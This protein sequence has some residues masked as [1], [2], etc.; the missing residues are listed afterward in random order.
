MRLGMKVLKHMRSGNQS[1]VVS[2]CSI[3]KYAWS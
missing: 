1:R 3:I 2:Q